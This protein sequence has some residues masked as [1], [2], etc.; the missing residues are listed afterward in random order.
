MSNIFENIPEE[1]RF[2]LEFKYNYSKLVA[3]VRQFAN[4]TIDDNNDT[5][6]LHTN[7]GRTVDNGQ[8]VYKCD[9][10]I[11]LSKN[12]NMYHLDLHINK[13]FI[14]KQDQHKR[15]F[16]TRTSVIHK[17]TITSLITEINKHSEQA[18][19]CSDIGHKYR[20]CYVIN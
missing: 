16:R 7:F 18:Q 13:K 4:L 14:N 6:Y 12:N 17:Y 1:L 20:Q 19:R 11:I 5:V 9:M 15:V 8:F 2:T 10:L 3:D